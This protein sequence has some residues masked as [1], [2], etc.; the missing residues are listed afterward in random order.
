MKLKQKP[1]RLSN[2]TK[3][4]INAFNR[5]C[6]MRYRAKVQPKAWYSDYMDAYNTVKKANAEGKNDTNSSEIRE[7]AGQEISREVGS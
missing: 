3:L 4:D 2:R 7:M 5:A 1:L 6:D